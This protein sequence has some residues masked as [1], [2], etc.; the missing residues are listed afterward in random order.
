MHILYPCINQLSMANKRCKVLLILLWSINQ[1]LLFAQQPDTLIKKLDSLHE[2]ADSAGGQ[3]NI[4]RPEAYNENTKINFQNYFILLASDFKQ[5]V[6]KPFLMTRKDFRNVGIFVLVAG[7]LSFADEPVQRFAIDL[8]NQNPGML[9]FSRFVTNTGGPYE[10]I[11]LGVLASYGWIFRKEK[12]KTTSLLAS[13]AYIT[14]TVMQQLIKSLTGRQRPFFYDPDQ[15]EAEP[16]F[17]GPFHKIYRDVNGKKI[18]SSFPSGHTTAAFSAATVF[19]MEYKNVP[20]VKFLAYGSAT[21][22][23][24]SRITENKHWVTDVLTGAALGYLTGRQVVNNYHRYATIQNRKAKKGSVSMK[25]NY[26]FNRVLP[27]VVYTFR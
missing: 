20:W 18:G 11:T 13:Q 6:T 5:Q 24:F 2:K 26:E 10:A 15:V 21:L 16:R 14:S 25:L 7:A 4:I 9:K 27:G 8:R 12:I 3:V 1:S 22:I 17:R 19:A 23:G